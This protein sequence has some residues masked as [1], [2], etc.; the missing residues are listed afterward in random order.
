MTSKTAQETSKLSVADEPA[1]AAL[2]AASAALSVGVHLGEAGEHLADGERRYRH[3]HAVLAAQQAARVLLV[4]EELGSLRARLAAVDTAA[5]VVVAAGAAGA[6][7]ATARLRWCAGVSEVVLDFRGAG[8]ADVLDTRVGDVVVP[9][10]AVAVVGAA[11]AA[12]QRLIGDDGAVVA[13]A[14]VA[15]RAVR[16]TVRPRIGFAQ[17]PQVRHLLDDA[18]RADVGDAGVDV[19]IVPD[20]A[21][22]AGQAGAVDA[23]RLWGEVRAIV[24]R[25]V[26]TAL[27]RVA[28]GNTVTQ[29]DRLLQAVDAQVVHRVMAAIFRT[30]VQQ[31][32]VGV[33]VHPRG[34]R[35][36]R[37]A[38]LVDTARR[39]RGVVRRRHRLRAAAA[40][41]HQPSVVGVT[42]DG[43]SRLCRRRPVTRSPKGEPGAA[44]ALV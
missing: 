18:V 41:V 17:G 25:I 7:G 8:A 14:A 31:A 10:V 30:L 22:L 44:L 15:G 32:R 11:R 28:T 9:G 20:F 5:G 12:A 27:A 33:V 39:G 29:I 13:V 23:G 40:A 4:V 34:Q 35:L 43:S 16:L 26:E 2:T 3:H 42:A 19:V 21:R 38:V 24:T 6:V 37:Q 36:A 1:S